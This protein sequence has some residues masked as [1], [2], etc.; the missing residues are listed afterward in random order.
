MPNH[1][2]YLAGAGLLLVALS[3][4]SGPAIAQAVQATL[5]RNADE[6]GR[7]PYQSSVVLNGVTVTGRCLIPVRPTS[8]WRR[9]PKYPKARG[10]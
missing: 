4:T 8:A 1:R 10:W 6:P 9:S 3:I 2:V 5:T 7:N